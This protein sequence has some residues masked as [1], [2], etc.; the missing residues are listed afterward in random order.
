[1][2]I[3]LIPCIL[4]LEKNCKQI[5][6]HKRGLS[7]LRAYLYISGFNQVILSPLRAA[8]HAWSESYFGGF[9]YI[10]YYCALFGS[11]ISMS[12]LIARVLLQWVNIRRAEDSCDWKS[13]IDPD[14]KNISW[15]LKYYHIIGNPTKL[16]CILL[17]MTFIEAIITVIIVLLFGLP[18]NKDNFQTAYYYINLCLFGFWIL[19]FI[20]LLLCFRKLKKFIDYYHIRDELKYMTIVL[21]SCMCIGMIGIYLGSLMDWH[22]SSSVTTFTNSIWQ[23]SSWYL[24]T[25]WVKKRNA[26]SNLS[27]RNATRSPSVSRRRSIGSIIMKTPSVTTNETRP[28]NSGKESKTLE[29]LESLQTDKGM[30]LF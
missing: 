20:V 18:Y 3:V 6:F 4:T 26:G 24:S 1:M 30:Q 25:I 11:T 19:R 27:I 17:F 23:A 5:Y 9:N 29:M 12:I 15:V 2:V 28:N 7:L 21:L 14:Y 10:F 8:T 22:H 13:Q 16:L